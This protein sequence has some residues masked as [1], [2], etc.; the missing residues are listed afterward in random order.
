MEEPGHPAVHKNVINVWSGPR[1]VSTS[2]MYSFAQRRDAT[3]VSD[4]SASLAP[5]S[6]CCWPLPGGA[7]RRLRCA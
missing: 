3:Q 4:G 5:P 2:L 1:C 6:C 7:L